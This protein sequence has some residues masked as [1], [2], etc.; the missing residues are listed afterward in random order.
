MNKSIVTTAVISA[1]VGGIVGGV[2]TYLTVNN[3]L[4]TRYEDWANGEIEMVKRHYSL[5]RKEGNLSIFGE[6]EQEVIKK[7]AELIEK[8][9]YTGAQEATVDEEEEETN[10]VFDTKIEVDGEGNPILEDIPEEEDDISEQYPR[11]EGEPYL[12]SEDEY[13]QNEDD[14]ELDTL[15]YYEVDDTLTD[16]KNSQIERVEET[17]GVRHLHAFNF[18][19][20]S[21][22]KNSIFVRNDKHQSLYEVILVEES[23]ASVVMGIDDETL[24]LKEPKRRPRRM[25]DDD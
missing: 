17:I 3:K 11:I 14:Y 12:I 1:T 16:E 13:F 21:A 10:N 4:R 6:A 7:G 9:G 2:V 19:K 8:L 15:T 5:I 25:R 24:G 22:K 23:Y 18:G 20:N